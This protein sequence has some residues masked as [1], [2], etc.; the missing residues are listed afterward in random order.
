MMGRNE[1]WIRRVGFA[2][3][4][5]VPAAVAVMA[6]SG[7]ASATA[8]EQSALA[9]RTPTAWTVVR[10]QNA[11]SGDTSLEGVAALSRTDAWA[12]GQYYDPATEQAK[13]LVQHWDGRSWRIVRSPTVGG[14]G[15]LQA[16]A[17]TSGTD[18][19]AVGSYATESTSEAG[20]RTLVEHWDGR[21]WRVVPSPNPGIEG[22]NGVLRDVVALNA[23]DAWAVGS[24]YPDVENPTLQPLVER[25]DGT[26]WRVVP[27]SPSP[28]PWSVLKAVSGSGPR[29]V[30]AVGVQ[31]VEVRGGST[32]RALA[33]HWDG[34][35]WKRVRVPSPGTRLQPFALQDVVAV[36]STNAWAVGA[37]ATRTSHR[38][39]AMHWNG[40]AWKI[41]RSA[42][43]SSKYQAFAA[44]T[45]DSARSVWAVGT[46]YDAGARRMR[47]LVERWDGKRFRKVAS[48]DRPNS[49]L[50]DVAVIRGAAF[51]VGMFGQQP[52]RTLVLQ[53]PAPA[54]RS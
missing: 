2:L 20:T 30:W 37:L 6:A 34:V 46:Y 38:T 54:G 45:A 51:A 44:V 8:T 52:T 35:A 4:V 18:V 1:R 36:S 24:Y 14:K 22:G 15:T 16:V 13:T 21:E 31:D 32:E 7:A 47:T 12:V 33:L 48:G 39:V 42:N 10:S 26:A 25:W 17:A 49:E 27:V 5:L 9:V 28:G 29:D 3:L 50:K 53:S 11:G 41:V 19:W 40:K 23:G 43:P